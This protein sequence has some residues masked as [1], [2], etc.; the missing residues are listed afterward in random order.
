[1][2]IRKYIFECAVFVCGAVV[3]VFELTGSRILG[4]YLGATLYVWTSLIG[5]ILGSLS[6]GYWLG[7]KIADRKADM[8]SFSFIIFASALC[9][10]YVYTIKNNILEI[11]SSLPLGSLE[12]RSLL[13]S[14]ILF[15]PAS[16]FLGIISPY[17]VKLRLFHIDT[18][19]STVGTLYALSTLGSIA[20]TFGAGFF[21]IPSLGTDATLLLLFAIL[22]GTA[23]AVYPWKNYVHAFIWSV[24]VVAI[25]IIAYSI[26][27][28][29]QSLQRVS[30]ID[31]DTP[32]N[33]IWI[34]QSHNDKTGKDTINITNGPR[35]IHSA[36]FVDSNDLVFEYTKFYRLVDHFFPSVQRALMIGGGAYT[37]PR[38]FLTYHPKATIDVVEIDPGMTDMARKYFRL[39]DNPRLRIIHK[40]GRVFLN[41]AQEKTY[42][43]IFNDAFASLTI[44]FHLTTQ[45]TIQKEYDVLSEKGI[46][47]ANIISS[48]A[49]EQ[50]KFL[51]AEY[52]TYKSVFPYVYIFPVR[53]I[54]D[55]RLLQ[56]IMLVALKTDKESVLKS[57]DPELSGYLSHIWS[58]FLPINTHILTDD[59]APVEYL[60]RNAL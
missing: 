2:K 28:S 5:V 48:L 10:I 7:G 24:L 57:A 55:D 37:Y 32:Y 31:K 6:F 54:H 52:A 50:S 41:S 44:P 45:E 40:D 36:M 3:M 15:A 51:Q 16:I 25:S 58:G 47:I 20:G 12:F 17:A 18:S 53:D 11:F 23:L 39:H 1:M 56:N 38:D 26:I 14:F 19:A 49:G 9:I 4:P 43:V 42:D 35:I 59:F 46:V 13:I 27:F 34:F 60:Q 22:I 30:V 21:I 33:R 8:R 29:V